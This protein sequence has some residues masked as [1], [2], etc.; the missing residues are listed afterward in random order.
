MTSPTGSKNG[1]GRVGRLTRLLLGS[2][3]TL[4]AL[5]VAATAA[6]AAPC[7]PQAMEYVTLNTLHVDVGRLQ[8][9]YSKGEVVKVK[10]AV[11]RPSENDPVGLG[12]SMERPVSEPA[13]GVNVGVGISI[14]RVFL[15]GYSISDKDGKATVK[16]KIASY[17]PA[18]KMAQLQVFAYQERLNTPCLIVEEQGYEARPN[19]F[20]VK[21]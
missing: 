7:A 5:P 21:P 14:G 19:A 9:A 13:E 18:G 1:T 17:A 3:I 12:V 20:K 4:G 15:P 6:A 10:V 2:A 16:I 11:S 8:R